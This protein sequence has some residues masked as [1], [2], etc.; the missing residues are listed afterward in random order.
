MLLK[1]KQPMI[2][3]VDDATEFDILTNI[4]VTITWFI[5]I[6]V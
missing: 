5:M 1:R 2:N 4:R 3:A 6:L